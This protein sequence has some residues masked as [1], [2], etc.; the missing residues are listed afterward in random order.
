MT[1]EMDPNWLVHDASTF[2]KPS[3]L[4][5]DVAIV[6]SGAGGGVTAEILS[7][8]GLKA[9]LIEE[10]PLW[11]TKDFDMKES[12][13]YPNL[14]QEC[15]NRATKNKEICILQGR[16]VGGTTT[17]NWTTS[18]RT[19]DPTLNHWAKVHGIDFTPTDLAPWFTLMEERLHIKP[20]ESPPNQNNAAL[21]RAAKR[22]GWRYGV[23][24]RNV[25]DCLDLGYCGVGC[26][27]G[28][29]QSM[30]VTTIPSALKQGATLIHHC[31]A[32]KLHWN[33]RHVSLIECQALGKDTI[34]PTGTTLQ[35]KARHV[36]LSCGSIGTP[37]L[38]LRSNAP[39]PYQLI[40]KRTFLHPT[41]TSVAK[42]PEKVDAFSGAPQSIYSDH[43]LWKDGVEGRLGYKLEVPPLHPVL[44]STMF[45]AHGE[46]HAKVMRD[47]P[48]LQAIIALGRDGFHEQSSGGN[49]GLYG[50]GSP[51]LDYSLND[52]LWE[53]FRRAYLSMAE[54]QFASGAKWV[55]PLH[56]DASPYTTWQN[57]RKAILELPLKSLKAIIA[58]A[59]VMGG[60]K[61]G[62]NPEH[63]VVDLN[64]KF[65]HLEN[66]FILD[67]S[68]FPTS[69]GANPQ[70]S[71]YAMV[72][73]SATHLA[74]MLK[75]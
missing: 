41:V 42:M 22:L 53:G 30:L 17:I 54:A 64:G 19:P 7:K 46:K 48:F 49:V 68:I 73:R 2:D 75:K 58:S 55:M 74:E 50:D 62:K 56:S 11:L 59:H 65:H 32:K 69:V 61:M 37:A 35:I 70:L 63:A 24:S 60:C 71:I 26:P 6:G 40:G 38:L 36:V 25:K 5:A 57:A 8:S 23:I 16:G 13:A 33:T 39:D 34:T 44:V 9:I 51:Y 67:G 14:Y 4:E 21:E 47:F 52:Y 18:F 27:V 29:K 43:F 72:A 45:P 28:A 15:A 20:W 66:L 31:R 3:S 10:G 12:T 1:N